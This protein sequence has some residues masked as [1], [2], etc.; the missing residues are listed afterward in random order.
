MDP[1]WSFG[2]GLGAPLYNH[3]LVISAQ[4][5]FLPK[6]RPRPKTLQKHIKNNVVL[7]KGAS[8]T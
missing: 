2:G 4:L 3:N 5:R 6:D 1:R 8:G 7:K